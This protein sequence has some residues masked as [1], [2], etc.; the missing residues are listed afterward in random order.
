VKICRLA[1][2]DDE[3]LAVVLRRA[4]LLLHEQM[5]EG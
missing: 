2:L 1:A 4:H 5:E 3:R